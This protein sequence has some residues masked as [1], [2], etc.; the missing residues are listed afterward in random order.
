MNFFNRSYPNLKNYYAKDL[1][2]YSMIFG[3]LYALSAGITH[4]AQYALAEILRAANMV[5]LISLKKLKSMAKKQK[6]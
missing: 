4:S 2:G 6:L 5:S 3:T 1:F